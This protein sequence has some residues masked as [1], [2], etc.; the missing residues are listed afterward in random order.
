[1]AIDLGGWL[2]GDADLARAPY[3][4]PYG[5]VLGGGE[6]LVLYRRVSGG[7]EVQLLTPEDVVADTVV[8]GE[9]SADASYARSEDGTW[10]I[11]PVPSPGEPNGSLGS[12]DE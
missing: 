11:C 3:Q 5:T 6:H 9:V 8:F 4:L 7:D 10:Q 12:G 2:L 1:M